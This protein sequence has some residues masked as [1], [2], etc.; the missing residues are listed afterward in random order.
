MSVGD[1]ALKWS[2]WLFGDPWE[3]DGSRKSHCFPSPLY[4]CCLQGLVSAFQCADGLHPHTI[5]I[6][7]PKSELGKGAQRMQKHTSLY[8]TFLEP[9]GSEGHSFCLFCGLQTS[10]TWGK[11]F[12][13]IS[14]GEGLEFICF[15][16]SPGRDLQLCRNQRS[17]TD[18]YQ[19]RT[20][21][22]VS[23]LQEGTFGPIAST[24]V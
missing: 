23:L 7:E 17:S 11:N 2:L 20:W 10:P 22:T 8:H 9:L 16:K 6:H 24:N 4:L 18:L 3:N 5:S 13:E 19:L 15:L 21:L 12:K 1:H 14:R